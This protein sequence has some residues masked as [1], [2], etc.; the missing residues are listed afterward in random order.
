MK[1]D[2]V[3]FGGGA[4]GLWLLDDL[5]ARGYQVILVEAHALGQG[6]TVASQGILHGGLK[7]T[8]T[9]AFSSSASAIRGM[10][11]LWSR[12]MAGDHRPVLKSTRLRGEFCYLWQTETL[13]SRLGMFAAKSALRVKPTLLDP[14]DWPAALVG[15][16]QKVF[17][18][19]EQVIDPASL[20]EDLSSR[21]LH[22]ILRVGIEDGLEF[23]VRGCGDV[24]SIRIGH[25]ASGA[26]SMT[27]FPRAVV[28]SAGGGN[29]GLRE[30]VGLATRA[31]QVRP[32]HMVMV[33]GRAGRLPVF[34]GHCIDGKRTRV[35]I[36]S[37]SDSMGRMIWQV[38]GQIAE[39]GVAMGPRE[40]CLHAR[41]ELGRVLRS[42][43]FQGVEWGTY[44]VDRAEAA[45]AGGI[46]PE[47]AHVSREGNVLTCWPTK[48]VLVPAMAQLAVGQL[49]SPGGVGGDW[50]LIGDWPRP[51]V[52]KPPWEAEAT[53]FENL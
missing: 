32:L 51:A 43:D 39:D 16:T 22:Q 37:A 29:A 27:L 26:G 52:A 35:T 3:I 8:L 23:H 31:M 13:A 17:R 5:T 49:G 44:R 20:L 1:V 9:G 48:L 11:E 14:K 33:R 28:F 38:G 10:P 18:L 34:N 15:S 46:R 24:G 2:A 19:D 41:A 36:T 30:R 7:Y 45:T 50:G 25:G 40:L 12:C 21:R 4:A 47:T 53:W 42:V 6:Q